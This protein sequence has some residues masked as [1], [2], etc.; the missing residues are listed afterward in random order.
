MK[1]PQADLFSDAAPAAQSTDLRLGSKKAAR[2]SPAQQRF[3]RLL[4]KIDKL[5][6]RIA[7]IQTLGDVYRP[8]YE[9]TLAP[10][11]KQQM[12]MMRGMALW[13]DDRLERKGLSPTQKRAAVEIL[14]SLCLTLAADGDAAMAALHDK[15]SP[16]SLRQ[17]AEDDAAEVRALMEGVLGKPLEVDAQDELLH[18]LDAVMRA[19][20]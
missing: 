13:L 11:R 1:N 19:G 2:L 7:E 6:S 12:S 17:Q 15:R 8:L 18:P 3:N 16:R 10:L 9:S 20:H 4:E 14:C 5:K